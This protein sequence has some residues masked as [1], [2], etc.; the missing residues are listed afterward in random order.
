MFAADVNR[1]PPLSVVVEHGDKLQPCAERVQVLP[2]RRDS[3]LVSMLELGDGPLG[4]LESP[5][6]LNLTD[7]LAMTQLV[8]PELFERLVRGRL[9]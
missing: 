4:D 7:R 9:P 1:N 5:G 3:H 2:K 8:Q 6:E